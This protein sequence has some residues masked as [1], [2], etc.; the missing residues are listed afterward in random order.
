M[1]IALR[2]P[3]QLKKMRKA[4]DILRAAQ[5]AMKV[6]CVP[7]TTL[8]E[9]DAIAFDVI[10]KEGAVPNFLGFHGFP[11][12]ICAMLNSDVVHGIPDNRVLQE[13]DLLSVDCGAIWQG[14]HSDAAFSLVV[15]GAAAHPEREKFQQAVKKALLAGC[16][17]AKTGNTL[18]DIGHAI[19]REITKAGYS[20]CREY[21]GHGI[22][23][24][25][26]EDPHV[27][28]Y[29]QPGIGLPLKS[30]MTLCIEPI[31]ASGNPRV[32]IL[33]DGW[34]VVTVDGKD[35][36]QWEHCGVVTPNGLEIFA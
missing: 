23:N 33:S 2:T 24:E 29:G 9:L 35:A 26:H 25:M 18:G 27:F 3:E 4:G 10:K 21:T 28:N 16:S 20:L 30:G 7:G 11:G 32:K 14:W 6:K 34:T 19:E 13:G 1:K 17:A 36:C 5:E 22:G 31:V 12:T 8:K 15:G